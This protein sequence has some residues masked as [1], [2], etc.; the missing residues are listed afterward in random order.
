LP[1]GLLKN[2]RVQLQWETPKQFYLAYLESQRLD[3]RSEGFIPAISAMLSE[4]E[5]LRQKAPGNVS[6]E[7]VLEGTPQYGAGRMNVAGAAGNWILTD[8]TSL[9]SRLILRESESRREHA[10]NQL[11]FL[12][13][14]TFVLGGTQYLPQNWTVGAQAVYRSESF[15]TVDHA[16]RLPAGW[17]ADAFATWRSP[18]KDWRFSLVA[19]N[20]G[21]ERP[22]PRSALAQL[23]AWW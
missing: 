13:K 2:G 1:G 23:E 18:D 17:A 3:N 14:A 8:R 22:A 10:G 6:G 11:P 9:Y 20:L 21:R 12:P 15:T 7:D 4:L 5:K 16:T 19:K